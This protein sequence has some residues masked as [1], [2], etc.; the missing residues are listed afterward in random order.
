MRPRRASPS[1]ARLAGRNH[2]IIT[3]YTIYYNLILV[4]NIVYYWETRA[5]EPRRALGDR[6]HVQRDGACHDSCWL[7]LLV[8]FSITSTSNNSTTIIIIMI[9]IVI[10]P[11]Y[12][13]RGC[14]HEAHI[15]ATQL[16]PTA[17]NHI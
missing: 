2:I 3:S 1:P 15:G 16:D 13:P 8:S 17:S 14:R 4:C 10:I 7:V 5:A 9:S 6:P 11:T 12:W